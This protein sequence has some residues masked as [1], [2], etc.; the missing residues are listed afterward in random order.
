M[1]S[2]VIDKAGARRELFVWCL[3]PTDW[4]YPWL[5]VWDDASEAI[6]LWL[7]ERLF[8]FVPSAGFYFLHSTV[9]GDLSIKIFAI[10]WRIFPEFKHRSRLE[11]VPSTSRFHEFIW[12]RQKHYSIGNTVDLYHLVHSLD[13]SGH[14]IFFGT[15]KLRYLECQPWYRITYW[16]TV[17]RPERRWD[18]MGRLICQRAIGCG[19]R[20]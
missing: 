1:E 9:E 6:Y 18:R 14:I 17:R 10:F 7:I 16:C 15:S 12:R 2:V 5:E 20:D 3:S 11:L 19:D 13:P 8:V 4:W